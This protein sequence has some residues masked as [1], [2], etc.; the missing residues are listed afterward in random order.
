MLEK[1]STS[2][3]IER[4]LVDPKRRGKPVSSANK[5]RRSP[6]SGRESVGSQ[7]SRLVL[8]DVRK[9]RFRASGRGR[10]PTVSDGFPAIFEK[11]QKIFLRTYADRRIERASGQYSGTGRVDRDPVGRERPI[12]GLFRYFPGSTGKV[13]GRAAVRSFPMVNRFHRAVTLNRPLRR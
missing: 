12:D 10:E 3:E 2:T 5:G 7:K 13:S 9:K 1:G 4:G 6:G 8:G 11:L